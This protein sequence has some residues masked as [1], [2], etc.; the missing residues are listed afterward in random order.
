M[1]ATEQKKVTAPKMIEIE[2]GIFQMGCDPKRDN[3]EIGCFD[4]E[5]PL[6]S[7]TVPTFWLSETEV[8]VG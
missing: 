2:G 8:T 6:H 3:V 1:V 4:N 7:V 5:K